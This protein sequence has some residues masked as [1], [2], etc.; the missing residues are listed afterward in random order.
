MFPSMEPV[1]AFWGCP[2]DISILENVPVIIVNGPALATMHTY[3]YANGRV[4][5]LAP[6]T[7]KIGFA[8]RIKISANYTP[9][10][11]AIQL[12]NELTFLT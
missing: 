11:I 3:L 4:A 10:P 12:Q 9:I 2:S 8:N 5:S 1:I 6:N 7:S